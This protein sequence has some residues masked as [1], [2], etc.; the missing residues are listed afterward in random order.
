VLLDNQATLD[1]IAGA[2]LEHETIDASDIDLLMA[3][4]T[5]TRPPPVKPPPA[6]AVAE[7][8]EKAPRKAGLLDTIPVPKAEPGKA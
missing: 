6:P 2:L 1:K 3:G 4:G 8:A 7:K 5:I